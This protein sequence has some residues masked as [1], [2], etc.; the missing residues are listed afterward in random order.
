MSHILKDIQNL[1]TTHSSEA[2]I[3][4]DCIL[5]PLSQDGMEFKNTLLRMY[6]EEGFPLKTIVAA[7]ERSDHGAFRIYYIFAVPET[8]IFIVPFFDTQKEFPSLASKLHEFSTYECEIWTM[9]G[10]VP[11][12]H[13]AL[14]PTVLHANW[15]ENVFPLRKDFKWNER[16]PMAKGKP[17]E[18]ETV[19]GEGVYEIPVGPVHAG[20]IEPGHFRFSV[21]GEEIQL[22]DPQLGWKH[23]GVEKLFE[24]L[25]LAKK[26]SLSERVSGDSSFAHSL[27]FCQAVENLAGILPDKR[28]LFLR[29]IFAELE[30]VANHLNDIGFI[31]LDTAFSFGGAHGS[32]LRE[33][34][35]RWNDELTG[36][37]FLRGVNIPG[38]VA[39]DISAEKAEKLLKDIPLIRKDFSQVVSVA[40]RSLSL[41]NRLTP[42]GILPLRVVRDY[43]VVGVPAR[44]AGLRKDARKD[45]PY[46]AY[47]DFDFDIP[48][49]QGSG[50][51]ERLKVRILEVYESFKI[52]EQALEALPNEPFRKVDESLLEKNPPRKNSLAISTVEGWRGD[53][54]YAVT[55][56]KDAKISR[57]K[58]R[59]ASFL[60]WQAFPH[61]V[62]GEMVPDFP[63]INKSFDLSYS[64]NDL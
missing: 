11:V 24:T 26:I 12:G 13:P 49:R 48:T 47:N 63:L 61:T 58:V 28:A 56:D 35:L 16:P 5:F 25:P 1:Y 45:L 60:N 22:L 39:K 43:G 6:K 55:T 20:I 62:K 54:V 53:I 42:T 37:R 14:R 46:A 10:L 15:P 21:L 3:E 44:A 52:I 40:E 59:D 7:D 57:V 9:F 23:K 33:K 4:G 38:G 19:K 41:R 31:M 32:R 29:V 17:Y 51:L 36:S 30:R 34:I 8:N 64:G 50:V 27:A 2:R 18:F